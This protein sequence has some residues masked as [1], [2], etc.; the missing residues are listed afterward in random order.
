M[1]DIDAS[2]SDAGEAAAAAAATTEP[3]ASEAATAGAEGDCSEVKKPSKKALRREKR[4]NN[5]LAKK[6]EVGKASECILRALQSCAIV[7]ALYA[8]MQ[9]YHCPMVAWRQLCAM[10][11]ALSH[12][13]HIFCSA[14]RMDY[15]ERFAFMTQLVMHGMHEQFIDSHSCK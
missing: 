9:S 12:T 10:A 3:S 1:C 14:L 2:T 6:Q 4:H 13:E 7:A 15:A 5:T 8:N 11:S